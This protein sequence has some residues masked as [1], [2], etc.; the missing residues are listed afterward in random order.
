[1]LVI[2][3]PSDAGKIEIAP[4]SG[5]ALGR[6]PFWCIHICFINSCNTGCASIG[7]NF[8]I[9]IAVSAIKDSRWGRKSPCMAPRKSFIVYDHRRQHLG[10][11]ITACI[12]ILPLKI[13][14]AVTRHLLIFPRRKIASHPAMRR[15]DANMR[16]GHLQADSSRHFDGSGPSNADYRVA[17]EQ[18]GRAGACIRIYNVG[19]EIGQ[20]SADAIRE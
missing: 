2:C 14:R 20:E 4:L 1:M 11:T 18:Y 9:D 6:S 19:V 5:A 16:N 7:F 3:Y 12:T 17:T 15:R 10:L 8:V 13:Q